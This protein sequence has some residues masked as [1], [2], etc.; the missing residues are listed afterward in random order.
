MIYDVIVVGAGHAGCEAALAAARLGAETLLLTITPDTIAAMSC[1]PAIGGPAAKS[2]LV[3]E[4]DALGGEMGKVIDVSYL[5]IRRINESRGPAVTAL[6]AQADKRMYQSEMTLR[7]L[8]QPHLHVKQGLVKEL[9]V[10]AQQ[11][12]G[13]ILKSGRQ[14]FSKTTLLA[15]GTF[16]NGQVVMGNI[17]Y[18]GGR[19]GEP[20]ATELSESLIKHGI[21]LKRFQTATP[22]R[23]HRQSV[24]FSKMTPQPFQNIQWGFSWDGINH[25]R[26]QHHCWVTKTTP[27]TIEFIRNNLNLSPIFSG[28]INS[29]GPHFCPSIDRKVINFPKKTDHLIFLEPEGIYTEEMYLLGLT[30]AMPETIQEQILATIPGLEK[31]EI[32]RPGYAVEYDCLESFQFTPALESKV[33]RNLFTAG[34]INGTSGYE[35]AA[36]QGIVAGINAAR[37]VENLPPYLPS[38]TS[39]YIGVMIDDL[40]TKGTDEPYRMMTSLAE[41]RLFF[42]LDNALVR[43]AEN[44]RKIGLVN[45]ERVHLMDKFTR[46]FQDF[47]TAMET[48]KVK[49]D[50]EFWQK[51]QLKNPERSYRLKEIIRFPEIDVAILENE[52]PE[53]NDYLPPVKEFAI[54][55]LKLAGYLNR[56]QNNL[57]EAIRLELRSIPEDFD[58]RTLVKLSSQGR[59]LLEKVRP[60]SLGQALRIAELTADD[61]ALLLLQF[62]KVEGAG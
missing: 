56:Q 42:R 47:Q 54:T 52:F 21:K 15:T 59:A 13:V 57:D 26:E 20:S 4:L 28:S 6:R 19:Q 39:S 46:Q 61:R 40:A 17:R 2:H 49:K 10:E 62:G 55:D 3:R 41:Y 36:A 1:N 24:D 31:A 25:P 51:Y 7:L 12:K 50:A 29:K 38:R 8:R 32:V 34:Q 48:V 23:I 44:A 35:E 11:V 9:I 14:Y 43:L 33:I 58:Y 22:P 53:L 30:T 37:K 27:E 60:L 18:A 16:L 45:E 5:N